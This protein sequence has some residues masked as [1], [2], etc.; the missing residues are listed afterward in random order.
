MSF[1][2]R[3]IGW[4]FTNGRMTYTKVVRFKCRCI[5][6]TSSDLSPNDRT[7]A[8]AR[9]TK[10]WSMCWHCGLG[11][12][13]DMIAVK[14]RYHL[15]YW[16][17]HKA[18]ARHARPRK[19]ISI[20]RK[21]FK[22]RRSIGEKRNCRVE[23]DGENYKEGVSRYPNLLLW[24]A[25]IQQL[26]KMIKVPLRKQKIDW[27]FVKKKFQPSILDLRNNGG[28]FIKKQIHWLGLFIQSGLPT[29]QIATKADGS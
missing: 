3:R 6:A 12:C 8:V 11:W 21:K 4:P 5:S 1:I 2:I 28:R 17:K 9:K 16:N 23:A 27:G 18:R 14:R 22:T 29:V 19:R 7:I 24:F 20:V 26:T 10:Q 15:L 13:L 25:A